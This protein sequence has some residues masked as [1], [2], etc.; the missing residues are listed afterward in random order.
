MTWRDEL[1]I[2]VGGLVAFVFLVR[3]LIRPI[4]EIG[5]VFDSTQTALAAWWKILSLLEVPV[6][7]SEPGPSEAQDLPLGPLPGRG[8]R[9]RLLLPHRGRVLLG[10]DVSIPADADVAVVGETGSGKTTFVRL[11][12][13]LIDPACGEGPRG[14]RRLASCGAPVA[15]AGDPHGAP[16]RLPVRGHHRGQHPAT[17]GPVP[18]P[19]MR[20]RLSKRSGCGTGWTP[21]PLA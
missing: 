6:E 11:L 15:P 14:R 16:G 17:A 13:R 19:T 20:P 12:A 9:C 8:A 18:R 2:G 4:S 3:L 21:C 10:V 5:E 7:V 1:D